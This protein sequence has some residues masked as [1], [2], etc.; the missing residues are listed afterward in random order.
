VV[1]LAALSVGGCGSDEY[2][3]SP[4]PD[5]GS[6]L[7]G[8]PPRLAAIHDQADE[9]LPGGLDAYDARIAELKGFP[10]VVNVWASWCGPCRSEFP[11]LQQ[12]SAERG[13]EVAF[14]GVNSDDDEDAAETFLSMNGLSYPSYLDP[15]K[16]IANDIGATHGFPATAFYD[17][18]GEL[19]MVKHGEFRDQ[20]ELDRYIQDY[21]VA[22]RPG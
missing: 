19:T 11:L 2:E 9:L 8:S 22:G 12:A 14:L 4:A 3:G 5:Y 20:E 18:D 7:A 16:R 6:M 15:D 21:A 10:V 17:A 1:L 13:K